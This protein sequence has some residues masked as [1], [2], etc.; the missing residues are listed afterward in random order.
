MAMN[1]RDRSPVEGCHRH[2]TS[3]RLSIVERP[4]GWQAYHVVHPG[5][6]EL[7]YDVLQLVAMAFGREEALEAILALDDDAF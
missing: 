1:V 6:F 2:L 7:R 3:T 4:C 5:G